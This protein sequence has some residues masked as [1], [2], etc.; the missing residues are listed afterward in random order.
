M[1]H[2]G[3]KIM[4]DNWALKSNRDITLLPSLGTWHIH[5]DGPLFPL[6]TI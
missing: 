4:P 3:F 5:I 1:V 6:Q 2:C